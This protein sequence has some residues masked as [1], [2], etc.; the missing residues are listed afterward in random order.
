MGNS[1]LSLGSL[2]T[3]WDVS[4]HAVLMPLAILGG[5][6]VPVAL[7]LLDLL[8][9]GRR[10]S[11][12]SRT[13]LAM[14]AVVYLVGLGGLCLLHTSDTWP[15]S[16]AASSVLAI[17]TRSAGF[18]FGWS[19]F[20]T[21]VEWALMLLM[22]VGAGPGGTAGGIKVTTVAVIAGGVGS[23]LGGRAPGRI[24][25]IAL[26]WLA[27]YLLLVLVS[28]ILLMAF[29]PSMPAERLLLLAVS[30]AGNVGLAHDPV[31]LTGASSLVLSA[32]MLLGRLMPLAVLWWT[33]LTTPDA[34]I[35][36]G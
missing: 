18:A 17:N 26:V 8:F 27:S 12:Y 34:R 21:P 33:A 5:L 31:S 7:E 25:G 28:L 29:T 6:G 3:V 36:V 24:V 14:S 32:T 13:V 35:A 22:L 10:L 4:V 30:A 2:P 15:E 1:G 11:A 20:R 19:D 9:A 16:L 23:I